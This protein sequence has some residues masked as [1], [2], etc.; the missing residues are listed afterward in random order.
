MLSSGNAHRAIPVTS[1]LC[2]AVASRTPGTFPFQLCS[3]ST[4]PLRIGHSSGVIVVDAQPDLASGEI[5]HA[6][7]YRTSRRL[8]Q[9]EVYY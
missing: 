3:A 6:S 8:F 2:V 7:V 1:A 5:L 4:G 9:G